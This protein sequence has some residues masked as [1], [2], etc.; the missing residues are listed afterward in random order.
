MCVCMFVCVCVLSHVRLFVTPRTVNCQAPLPMGFSRQEGWSGYIY[1]VAYTR[2]Y[3]EFQSF[4]LQRIFLTQGSNLCLLHLLHSLP[5]LHY[6]LKLYHCSTIYTYVLVFPKFIFKISYNLMHFCV[7]FFVF[8]INN[9]I[10]YLEIF[11][12]GKL[13]TVS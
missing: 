4:L 6:L 3:T 8:L 5:L 7:L 2:L 10:F 1:S 9:L 11:L 12:C 13:F